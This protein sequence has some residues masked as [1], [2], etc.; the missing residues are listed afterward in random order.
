MTY[1]ICLVAR[2]GDGFSTLAN[3]C[4]AV[5]LDKYTHAGALVNIIA[6]SSTASSGSNIVLSGN[7]TSKGALIHSANGKY[8][9]LARS[10]STSINRVMGIVSCIGAIDLATMHLR[11]IELQ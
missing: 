8:L 1:A 2:K 5:F 4:T 10:A 6:L 11:C 9:A 7:A 3:A